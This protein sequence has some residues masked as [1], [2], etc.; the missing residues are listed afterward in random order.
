MVLHENRDA[1]KSSFR[2][3]TLMQETELDGRVFV[4][5]PRYPDDRAELNLLFS[6]PGISFKKIKDEN[7]W[8]KTTKN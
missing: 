8:N 1:R 4:L 5:D 3:G 7:R 2:I 6:K